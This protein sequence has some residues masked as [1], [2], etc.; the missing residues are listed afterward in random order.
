MPKVETLRPRTIFSLGY[1][2]IVTQRSAS[3]TGSG[4]PYLRMQASVEFD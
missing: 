1:Q 3:A 4:N 2:K